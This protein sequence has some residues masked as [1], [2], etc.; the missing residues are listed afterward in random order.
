[1]NDVIKVRF[2]HFK[3]DKERTP[4]LEINEPDNADIEIE[5]KGEELIFSSGSL[6]ACINKGKWSLNFY[7][8]N[9]WVTGSGY[10][11]MAYIRANRTGKHMSGN[12]WIWQWGNASMV[13]GSG[14]PIL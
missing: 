11:N 6:T 3:G 8:H 5:D 14:L 10:K 7:N 1:M 4:P 2:E 12:S 13:L 9:G